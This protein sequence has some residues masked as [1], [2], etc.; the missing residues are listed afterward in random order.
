VG[1]E[2][3]Y[4]GVTGRHS[5]HLNTNNNGQRL[6]DFAAAKNMAV[7]TTCSPHKEIHT[8]TWSSP[9]GKTKNKIDHILIDKRKASS[10]LDVK[11]CR[12]AS[13]DSGH[14]LVRGSYKCKIAYSKY[15]PNRTT[16]RLHVDALREASAVRRF[17]QQL[18]EEFGKLETERVTEEKSHIEEDWKQLKEV[19]MEAA[20]QTLGFQPKPDRRGWFD[21]ECRKALEEKNAAYKIWIGRKTAAKRMEY[22]GLRKIA[23]KICKNRKRTHMDNRIRDTEENIKDTQIR[24]AY[25]E[26]GSIKD[27]FQ[28]HANFCRGTNNEILSKEEDIKIRWKTYF[29][30]LL[31]PP[32]TADQSNPSEAIYANQADSE[33][34]LEEEPPDILDTEM[35]IQSMKNNRSRCIDNIPAELYKKGQD[36]YIIKYIA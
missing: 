32:A 29:K 30:D 20:E 16:R 9:D 2:E 24:N 18:E 6:V 35:A 14:F 17:R 27:G 15:E 7:T 25:K 26:T 21:D 23:H 5:M 12:G 31:T 8:Q 1:R 10:M 11:S 4:Q 13:S 34:E 36:Y 33:E 28:P 22:E 3:I 19:I